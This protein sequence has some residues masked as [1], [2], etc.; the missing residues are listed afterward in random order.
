MNIDKGRDHWAGGVVRRTVRSDT[1]VAAGGS[2]RSSCP[3]FRR[4]LSSSI[5]KILFLM[6]PQQ[7]MFSDIQ[8][9]NRGIRY[10]DSWDCYE[11]GTQ[12]SYAL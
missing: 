6:T 10:P 1:S 2:V 12:F 8:V 7:A 11:K 9:R 3:Q 4:E 5:E